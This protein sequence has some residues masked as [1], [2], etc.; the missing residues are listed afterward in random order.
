MRTP[1]RTYLLVGFL[2]LLIN[3]PLAQSNWT[4]WQVERH[5]EP[6][7]ATLVEHEV[8][9][10]AD[11]PRYWVSYR[12]LPPM[13]DQATP[14]VR[15]V[16]QAAYDAAVDSG[17][18]TVLVRDGD[19]ATSRAE[20][21]V[22]GRAGLVIAL[23]LNLLMLAYGLVL[24][25]FGSRRRLPTLRVEAV[26]DVIPAEG[27]TLID[28]SDGPVLVRGTIGEITDHDVVLDIGSRSVI[29]V[30]DGHRVLVADGELAQ[31][32]GHYL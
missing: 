31:V 18:V 8:L 30:L 32:R 10:S 16:D 15:R 27:K 21:Q 29:V 3:F 1:L 17:Q 24:W 22:V 7:T 26:E 14:L 25:R 2:L 19:L 4:R 12:V 23:G 9:G 20:G 6:T 28:E 5:G 13:D 11:D